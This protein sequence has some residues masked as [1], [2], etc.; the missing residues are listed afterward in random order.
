[1]PIFR[2][3]KIIF[4]HIT[5]AAGSSI[6]KALGLDMTCVN[7]TYNKEYL[8]H[9]FW[10]GGV[11]LEEVQHYTYNHYLR[12]GLI[13]ADMAKDY[14]KFAIVRN[15]YDRCVSEWKYQTKM[16]KEKGWFSYKRTVLP[17]NSFEE[18]VKH[19]FFMYK[20][21]VLNNRAH[22]RQQYLYIFDDKGKFL[23]DFI[24]RFENLAD[25]WIIIKDKTGLKTDLPFENMGLERDDYRK[26]YND[27]TR[28][29]VE[30]MYAKDLALLGY[31]F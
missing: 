19:L 7:E 18:Y 4:F 15:P 22:D 9:Y 20:K 5:K 21:G 16:F 31:C 6:E 13:K 30:K 8:V 29:M 2:D 10:C 23:L 12:K 27:K 14:F 1:M 26:Y 17:L 28:A 3:K 24:G 11:K 25:D